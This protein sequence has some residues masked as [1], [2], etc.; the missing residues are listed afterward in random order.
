[1][2][3]MLSW[4]DLRAR[5][6]RRSKSQIRRDIKSGKFPAPA[7]YCGQAPFWTDEQLDKHIEQ[8]IAEHAAKVA[9]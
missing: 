5:G 7:G 4:D 2:I 8:L 1:M 6:E 9:A 3:R